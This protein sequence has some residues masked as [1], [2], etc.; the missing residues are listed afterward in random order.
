M[1]MHPREGYHRMRG[2]KCLP[3]GEVNGHAV[4]IVSQNSRSLVS[5]GAQSQK[6]TVAGEGPSAEAMADRIGLGVDEIERPRAMIPLFPAARARTM[7]MLHF[8]TFERGL[9]RGVTR[10]LTVG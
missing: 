8:Y 3:K 10:P 6:R 9:S 1:T 5:T 7:S 4:A 2:L